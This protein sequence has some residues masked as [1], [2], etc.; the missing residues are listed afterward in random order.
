MRMIL[1]GLLMACALDVAAV[2]AAGTAAVNAPAP[3]ARADA[4][5]ALLPVISDVWISEAPPVAKNNAAF[6]T[7]KNGAG[8]DVLLGVET[9]V[10]E[11]AEMHE[12]SMVGS[13]MRMQRQS[14][15]HLAPNAEIKFAP[16]GR[17]IMLIN[18]KKPLKVG[19]RVALTLRFRQAGRV[20]VQAEV[21]ALNVEDG[22]VDYSGHQHH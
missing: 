12:M 11:V 22:E 9:S 19:D 6:L 2:N 21:R 15:I 14:R 17:H 18:M 16:G 13:L 10:A 5:K 3:N 7:L 20:T 8:N 4:A 1:A